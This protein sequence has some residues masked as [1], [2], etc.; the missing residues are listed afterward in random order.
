M[1]RERMKVRRI[2]QTQ[3][4]NKETKTMLCMLHPEVGSSFHCYEQM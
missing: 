1:K 4:V 3:E 2:K